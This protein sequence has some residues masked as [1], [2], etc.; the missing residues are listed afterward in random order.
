MEKCPLIMACACGE[1]GCRRWG[2]WLCFLIWGL[3]VG[4]QEAERRGCICVILGNE[5]QVLLQYLGV[6][7]RVGFLPNAHGAL[8]MVVWG[9]L[10]EY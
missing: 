2:Y 4:K 3:H 9:T 1:A 6:E 7:G 10:A 8:E 5:F